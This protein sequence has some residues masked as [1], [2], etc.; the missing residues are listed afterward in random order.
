MDSL[1]MSH[2]LSSASLRSGNLSALKKRWEQAGKLEKDK[3]TTVAPSSQRFRPPSVTKFPPIS[4]NC[5]PAKSQDLPTDQGDEKTSSRVLKAL[6]AAAALQTKEPT[7]IDQDENKRPEKLEEQVPTSPVAS[8]EKPRQPLN[9]LKMKFE[10][11]ED[12]VMKSGRTM[13]RSTS[14]EDTD[15]NTSP[16]VSDRAL[17]SSS[18]RD[19]LAKY[20]TA[21]S[22]RETPCTGLTSEASAAVNGQHTPECNGQNSEQPKASRR[23]GPPVKETCVACL[24]TV[25]PLER[26]VAHQHVYHKSCFRCVHCSTKLSLGNYAS[27]HGNIYCKPHF[28]Q[29]FKSKGNYDE[30]FG[31]RP[32]KELWE[33]HA[34]TGEESEDAGKGSEQEKPAKETRPAV[35]LSNEEPVTP[36]E[37]SPIMKVT[38]LTAM[39]ETRASS[40]QKSACAEK[41]A[42]TQRLRIAWPPPGGEVQARAP[43]MLSPVDEGVTSSRPRRGKWPPE[44]DAPP[45][46]QSSERAELTSLRRSSSL[47]ERIRPF[48]ASSKTSTNTNPGP[49]EPRRPLK[50][51]LEW[52]ASF[53][54]K[55]APEENKPKMSATQSGDGAQSEQR[56]DSRRTAAEKRAKEEEEGSLKSLS[57][58]VSASPSP[59]SQRKHNRTSQDV[60]FWEEDKEGSDVEELSAEDIIKR[61]RYYEEDED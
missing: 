6:D 9:N 49:Q 33:S 30:G 10:K 25:Y 26:L 11:G 38:D 41:A 56:N 32:H 21:V 48:T 12:P 1:Y 35:S 17:D 23:F 47:K 13:L 14:S 46:F 51:L 27:L 36:V 59:P 50:A 31:H 45:S 55:Q 15:Y 43:P 42:E 24:K 61:N 19:K 29:L 39:L 18:L 52:R 57:P 4:E 54:E 53:E 7:G 5:P 60:G 37:T 28:N 44:P 40:A 34:A 16:P 2:E 3:S 8:Y 20:Q 58:D 22:K